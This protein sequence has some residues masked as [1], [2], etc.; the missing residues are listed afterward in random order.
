MDYLREN[1]KLKEISHKEQ[2]RQEDGIMLQ[3]AEGKHLSRIL[4][5]DK[6]SF[7]GDIN[8]FSKQNKTKI[9]TRLD[10]TTQKPSLKKLSI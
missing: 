1:N 10:T 5:L 7:M 3:S 9:P 4:H 8:S 2:L 6:L